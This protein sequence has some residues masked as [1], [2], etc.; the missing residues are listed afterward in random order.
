[1]TC[2]PSFFFEM[3]AAVVYSAALILLFSL[4][5]GAAVFFI[6]HCQMKK[7]ED[8]L[9]SFVT[10]PQSIAI[11]SSSERMFVVDH[12]DARI[13]SASL[14]GGDVRE[15]ATQGLQQ[16]HSVAVDVA[17]SKLYWTDVAAG[18][19]QRSSYDGLD[20]EDVV[21]GLDR[22]A[23]IAVV[24]AGSGSS[25]IPLVRVIW[26]SRGQGKI[27][28]ASMASS[29]LGTHPVTDM[30]SGGA[31]DDV[32][33]VAADRDYVYWTLPI[34][35]TIKRAPIDGGSTRILVENLEQPEG[36]AVNYE[37]GFVY[38]SDLGAKKIGRAS[39]G[40]SIA[41][42]N[43]EFVVVT[44]EEPRGLAF[45]QATSMYFGDSSAQVVRRSDVDGECLLYKALGDEMIALIILGSALGVA[46][47]GCC[48]VCGCLV[49]S[50]RA[51]KSSPPASET[52]SAHTETEPAHTDAIVP[53]AAA[54]NNAENAAPVKDEEGYQQDAAEKTSP[55]PPALDRA[56]DV[57]Q[58]DGPYKENVP[59]L[60]PEAKPDAEERGQEESR[61][62][63]VGADAALEPEF[64][65]VRTA[66]NGKCCLFCSA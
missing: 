61:T 14:E 44:S 39:I 19:V 6:V 33:G 36:I 31:V 8:L 21:V 42:S 7:P 57:N 15:L 62:R 50:R 29:S 18:K 47:L 10:H 24:S 17:A 43:M 59:A 45:D 26:A 49:R 2:G 28:T 23:G 11:D 27:Q 32:F 65:E 54:D 9:G 5:S 34:S 46:V 58:E 52:N 63:K 20:V 1:M 16:P 13:L 38:W 55:P 25:P 12:V 40:S 64:L 35:G 22:P 56:R 3:Q 4:L 53:A 48:V 66:G 30:S 51:A 37:E 41:G 60:L